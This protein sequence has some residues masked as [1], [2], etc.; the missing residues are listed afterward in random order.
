MKIK[1]F[2]I[3]ETL[4][5]LLAITI[6]ITA[7]LT[8]MYRSYKY[9]EFINSKVIS[10]GLAQ[11]GIELVTSFRNYDLTNFVQMAQDCNTGCMIDWDGESQTP[12]F[13]QCLDDDCKLYSDTSDMSNPELYRSSGDKETGQF[14]SIK[15]TSNG[16]G[17]YLLES[18][19]WSYVENIKVEAK[20]YKMIFELDIKDNS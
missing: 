18:R 9:S 8:F 11:E 4:T 5:T 1:A 20:L 13:Y 3:I 7:P 17:G 12:T 15:L 2:T 10:L 19:A 6:M 16:T 14:R